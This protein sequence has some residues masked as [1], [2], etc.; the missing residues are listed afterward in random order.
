MISTECRATG[1]RRTERPH[2]CIYTN[3]RKNVFSARADL[4]LSPSPLRWDHS[5]HCHANGRGAHFK[6][7]LVPGAYDVEVGL[8]DNNIIMRRTVE[9]A[10]AVV[11]G[12]TAAAA[13]PV[14]VCAIVIARERI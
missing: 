4:S 2:A 7:R 3:F 8:A 11:G 13:A 5:V 9:A 14:C 12:T 1:G 6:T 10:A